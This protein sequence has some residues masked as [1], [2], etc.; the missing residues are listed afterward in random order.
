MECIFCKIV[1]G[2]LPCYKVYEDEDFLGFLDIRPLTKG[3][4]LI[5]PKKHFRWVDE[6]PNFGDYFEVAR[7]AGL[8]AKK[9]FGAKW[10]SY[11]TIGLEVPHAH[12]RVIPRYPDDLHGDL[13]D[14]NKIEEFSE[15]EMKKIAEKISKYLMS[16]F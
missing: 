4:S 7:K 2:E 3:N 12:I 13:P 8:A 9:V 16:N 11:I 15:N 14:L 6:V 1:K 5:I 10:I